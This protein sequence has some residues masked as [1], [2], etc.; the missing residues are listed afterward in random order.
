MRLRY[1]EGYDLY[2]KIFGKA[3]TLPALFYKEA[4]ADGAY[5]AH[6]AEV[7]FWVANSHKPPSQSWFRY[8]PQ[9]GYPSSGNSRPL[10]SAAGQL[11]T[12]NC[13]QVFLQIAC[14]PS[15]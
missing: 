9:S 14:E 4:L 10:F 6:F 5:L 8:K 1:I 11:Q 3:V 7:P 15:G 12:F 13:I 2:Q